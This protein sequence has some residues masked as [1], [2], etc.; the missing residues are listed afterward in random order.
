M[1]HV[2]F[3]KMLRV[4]SNGCETVKTNKGREIILKLKKEDYLFGY[5]FGTEP[6]T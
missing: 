1:R 2:T 6:L 4:L 3:L 5:L